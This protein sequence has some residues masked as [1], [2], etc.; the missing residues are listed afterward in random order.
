MKYF[1]I[2]IENYFEINIKIF[3]NKIFFSQ[4]NFKETNIFLIFIIII[5]KI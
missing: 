1:N 3:S 5:K 2:Y 4:L